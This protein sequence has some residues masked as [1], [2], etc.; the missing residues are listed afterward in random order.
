MCVNSEYTSFCSSSTTQI[1]KC[2]NE[3]QRQDLENNHYQTWDTNQ[4]IISAKKPRASYSIVRIAV[5]GIRRIRIVRLS[6]K[7]DT[8][9]VDT[10]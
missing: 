3:R 7:Y 6:W 2:V 4:G 5:F 1:I 9:N 8:G 10:I